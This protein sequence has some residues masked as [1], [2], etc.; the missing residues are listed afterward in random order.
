MSESGRRAYGPHTSDHSGPKSRDVWEIRSPRPRGKCSRRQSAL[1]GRAGRQRTGSGRVQCPACFIAFVGNSARGIIHSCATALRMFASAG[2]SSRRTHFS[3]SRLFA[4]M[5]GRNSMT[6]SRH[7][8]ASP[9]RRTVAVQHRELQPA[10][11]ILRHGGQIWLVY[12]E[13]CVNFWRQRRHRF[14][15]ARRSSLSKNRSCLLTPPRTGRRHGADLVCIRLIGRFSPALRPPYQ[16][17]HPKPSPPPRASHPWGFQ[18]SLAT[19]GKI[20]KNLLT[21]MSSMI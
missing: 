3:W 13:G 12:P 20:I 6:L 19:Q 5:S 16:P 10:F 17:P 14:F 18:R 1:N 9:R 8:A 7:Q 15:G 4:A 2:L 21:S 11:S